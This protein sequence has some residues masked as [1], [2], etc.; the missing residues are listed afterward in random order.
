MIYLGHN[1]IKSKIQ[2]NFDFKFYDCINCGY[3]FWLDDMRGNKLYYHDLNNN[4]MF[5][6]YTE[7]SCNDLIIKN[8]I[9]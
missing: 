6:V 2:T 4:G 9:E 7:L 8:I 5:W 3:S 1:F